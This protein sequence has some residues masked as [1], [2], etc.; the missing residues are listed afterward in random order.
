MNIDFSNI[1][2]HR[3]VFRWLTERYHEVCN[4]KLGKEEDISGYKR[5]TF[6]LA[7]EDIEN[8]RVELL[9]IEELKW[10]IMKGLPL[11]NK[12]KK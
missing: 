11:P 10:R 8:Y 7:E 2:K 3:G 1:D 9:R 4:A 6:P 5:G 12:K